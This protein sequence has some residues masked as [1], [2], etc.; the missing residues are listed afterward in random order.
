MKTVMQDFC[1]AKENRRM[2][3]IKEGTLYKI[4]EVEG[5][6]FELYYGYDSEEEKRRGWEPTPIYPDFIGQPQYT[7]SG[8]RF[9]NAFQEVCSHYHKKPTENDD[10]WCDLCE[11]FERGD[12]YIGVCKCQRNKKNE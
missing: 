1:F 8:L 12:D 9:A 6:R 5:T 3:N 2:E 11:H 10:D 4:T 7:A